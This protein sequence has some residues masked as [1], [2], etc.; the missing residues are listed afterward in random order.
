LMPGYLHNHNRFKKEFELPI[1]KNDDESALC[2]LKKM[3]TPFILRR[4]KSNVLKELPPKTETVL[5]ARLDGEQKQL[6]SANLAKIRS[7]LSSQLKDGSLSGSRVI[8]L[9][10]LTR[11]RQLC[12]DPSLCYDDYRAGS[13]K[14]DL[15]L[16]LLESSVEA[17]HKVLLFS[18]FTSMLSIIETQLKQRAI[19]YYVLKGS[20]PKEERAALTNRFNIDN[21][22]IFLIS[23]KAGGTGLN[24]TG[25][26]IVIHYDPWW[27]VSAQNQATDR[28]HRIGQQNSVQVYKLIA[29]NTIEEK[30]IKLQQDKLKLADSVISDGD[31]VISKMSSQEILDLFEE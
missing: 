27:N 16:E 30:I 22:K 18:Q 7:Q 15:C 23:L 20:T 6:Y 28:A 12:C 5:Y 4:L 9:A 13:A 10:M 3:L 8:V 17:G 24:L 1:V 26:D 25:A 2:N 21:T 19:S 31:G 14:L 11:L 29:K